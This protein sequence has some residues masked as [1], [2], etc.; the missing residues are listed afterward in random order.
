MNQKTL[1]IL[2]MVAALLMLVYT[3]GTSWAIPKMNTGLHMYAIGSNN[4]E[5]CN[6]IIGNT[7]RTCQITTIRTNNDEAH[8]CDA[9]ESSQ[10]QDI[11]YLIMANKLRDNSICLERFENTTHL[12]DCYIF[13]NKDLGLNEEVAAMHLNKTK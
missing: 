4:S 13:M 9:L 2:L 3:I 7:T 10:D 5:L 8:A 11:C 6:F 1:R 12:S